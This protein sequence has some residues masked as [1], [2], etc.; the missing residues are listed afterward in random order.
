MRTVQNS[1]RKAGYGIDV[2]LQELVEAEFDGLGARPLFR[3]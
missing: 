1:G 3:K 2:E